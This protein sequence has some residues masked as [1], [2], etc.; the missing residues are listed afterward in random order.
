[1]QLAAELQE[2]AGDD[3]GPDLDP[4]RLP[5]VAAVLARELT[6]LG[7]DLPLSPGEILTGSWAESGG[8]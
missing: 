6:A 8:E 2:I 3:T 1:L 5:R 7:L 4:T